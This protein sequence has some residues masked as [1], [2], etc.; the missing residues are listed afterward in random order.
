MTISM[1]DDELE[2]EATKAAGIQA[3]IDLR[4]GIHAHASSASPRPFPGSG[5]T[6]VDCRLFDLAMRALIIPAT[7]DV[8]PIRFEFGSD[9]VRIIVTHDQAT[10]W[11]SLPAQSAQDQLAAFELPFRLAKRLARV[12]RRRFSELTQLTFRFDAETELLEITNPR[13]R[14]RDRSV[15]NLTPTIKPAST[16]QTDEA[17]NTVPL[18]APL[19]AAVLSRATIFTTGASR[20]AAQERREQPKGRGRVQDYSVVRVVD[21]VAAS[22]LRA[23]FCLV[24]APGL[25]NLS[26]AV[27]RNDARTLAS[28]LSRMP[29]GGPTTWSAHPNHQVVTDGI[30][31]FS[32]PIP[33]VVESRFPDILRPPTAVAMSFS[34]DQLSDACFKLS[35]ACPTSDAPITLTWTGHQLVLNVETPRNKA[36]VTVEPVKAVEAAAL[37]SFDHL[38][39]NLAHFMAALQG[40]RSQDVSLEVIRQVDGAAGGLRLKETQSQ[41]TFTAALPRA[42]GGKTAH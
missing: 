22:G 23:A 25:K 38:T 7:A 17:I 1:L 40:I 8:T 12:W 10:F 33:P 4:H 5:V 41:F 21:G 32:F 34:V 3:A 14:A 16:P 30:V 11:I 15:I 2:D 24:Q 9:H 13:D 29:P 37:E 27:G 28:A 31:G 20:E 35:C 26:F 39:V 42:T 36:R 18:D 19:L 6:E